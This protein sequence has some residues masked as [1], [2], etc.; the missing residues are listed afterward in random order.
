MREEKVL[1]T[2]EFNQDSISVEEPL[3]LSYQMSR[4]RR[5]LLYSRYNNSRLEAK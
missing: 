1:D 2:P 4:G 5:V 3:S